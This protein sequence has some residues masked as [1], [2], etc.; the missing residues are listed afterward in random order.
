[1]FGNDLCEM[2]SDDIQIPVVVV[3]LISEIE[4]KGTACMKSPW[5][6]V[7]VLFIVCSVINS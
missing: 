7:Y 1:M 6:S 5:Q 2:V 3:K 4:N